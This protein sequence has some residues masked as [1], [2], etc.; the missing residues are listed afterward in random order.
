M[1]FKATRRL[2]DPKQSTSSNNARLPNVSSSARMLVSSNYNV[3]ANIN[4]G[5]PVQMLNVRHNLGPVQG[6]PKQFYR[7]QP[8]L[9]VDFI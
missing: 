8:D 1:G 7:L 3:D 9:S 5:Y 4:L 2:L 6:Y